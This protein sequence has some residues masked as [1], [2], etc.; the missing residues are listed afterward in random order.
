[1]HAKISSNHCCVNAAK[2][3]EFNFTVFSAKKKYNFTR[4]SKITVVSLFMSLFYIKITALIS[5]GIKDKN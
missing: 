1:M 3:D 2:R 4:K 5:E